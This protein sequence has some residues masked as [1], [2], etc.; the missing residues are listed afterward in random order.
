MS[1]AP[2]VED[3]QAEL[4]NANDALEELSSRLSKATE[5]NEAL[6][7][8]IADDEK[9]AKLEEQLKPLADELAATKAS[10]QELLAA[11]ET[12]HAEFQAAMTSVQEDCA[13]RIEEI[14]H[15]HAQTMTELQAESAERIAAL[16]KEKEAL[17]KEKEAL[18]KEK[19]AL[20]ASKPAAPIQG[21]GGT[22]AHIPTVVKPVQTFTPMTGGGGTAQTFTP[23]SGGGGGGSGGAH[24][25]QLSPTVELRVVGNQR[26]TFAEGSLPPYKQETPIPLTP[27]QSAKAAQAAKVAA[28]LAAHAAKKAEREKLAVQMAAL[29]GGSRK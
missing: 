6:T 25:S 27:E 4:T 3:L 1:T 2:T 17:Q 13:R 24:F 23:M 11:R 9:Y 19:E 18:Q 8:L 26:V 15:A 21:G 29:G 28:M 5:H 20:I 16:Q 12:Q 14:H 7:A 10:M 22:T